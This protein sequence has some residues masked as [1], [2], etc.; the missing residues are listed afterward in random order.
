MRLPTANLALLTSVLL[1]VL[2]C[3]ATLSA[4]QAPEPPPQ[5]PR[6]EPTIE[7]LGGGVYRIEEIVADR[8]K[9][10]MSIPGKVASTTVLEYLA[11]EREGFKAYE[12]ALELQASAE[13]FNVALILIGL[14]SDRGV[15]SRHKFDLEIPQ[16]DPVE[17]WVEWE[18]AGTRHRVRAEEL[19]YDQQGERTLDRSHWVYTGSVLWDSGVFEA[20]LHGVLIGFLHTPESIVDLP[21]PLDSAYGAHRVNPEFGL[22]SGHPVTVIVQSLLEDDEAGT[23]NAAGAADGQ[24]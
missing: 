20:A 13:A 9:R 14:D 5:P 24:K 1:A 2:A 4:Q 3:A 15:P 16:G 8:G 19:I 7:D 11:C 23:A 21:L 6:P 22:L 10:R 17:I 12:S 18:R